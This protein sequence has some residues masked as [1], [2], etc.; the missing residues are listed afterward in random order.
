MITFLGIDNNDIMQNFVP[1]AFGAVNFTSAA[2]MYNNV[3]TY[4]VLMLCIIV[5]YTY[6]S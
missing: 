3:A 2:G 4:T 6:V 1:S 5:S